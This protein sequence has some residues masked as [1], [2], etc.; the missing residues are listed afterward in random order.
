MFNPTLQ[1]DPRYFDRSLLDGTA[2]QRAREEAEQIFT[3]PCFTPEFARIL[4]DAAE[5]TGRW[6]TQDCVLQPH[7]H[8]PTILN[9]YCPEGGRRDTTLS[10]DEIDGLEELFEIF[11]QRHLHSLLKAFWPAFRFRRLV[12]PYLARYQPDVVS[13]MG[14]HFD[15]ETISLVVYLNDDFEGG[16]TYFPRW[17]YS[18]AGAPAG[19]AVAFPGGLSH[20]HEALSVTRG[21]RYILGAGIL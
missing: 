12:P 2:A 11:F 5:R 16:G 18:T 1:Y 21:T 4:I 19:S 15:I 17:R 20:V 3:F 7:P 14:L 6:T 8:D 9:L 13:A 10:G